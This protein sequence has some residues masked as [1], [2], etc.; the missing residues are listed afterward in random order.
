VRIDV[1]LGLMNMMIHV[2]EMALPPVLEKIHILFHPI[3]LDGKHYIRLKQLC[4]CYNISYPRGSDSKKKKHLSVSD[5]FI[6]KWI[7]IAK[8]DAWCR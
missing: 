2:P 1:G 6:T 4:K 5:Y 8:F 3:K 7:N